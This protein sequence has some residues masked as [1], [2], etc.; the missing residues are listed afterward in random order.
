MNRERMRHHISNAL[1]WGLWGLLALGL[2]WV[3]NHWSLGSA[4]DTPSI[5]LSIVIYLVAFSSIFAVG[6]LQAVIQQF[7]EER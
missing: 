6:I 3:W 5:V 4:R 1:A 7:L 2:F